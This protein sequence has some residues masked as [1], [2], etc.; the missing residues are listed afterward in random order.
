MFKKA[1]HK[2]GVFLCIIFALSMISVAVSNKT[3]TPANQTKTP[4]GPP[5]DPKS[6]YGQKVIAEKAAKAQAIP[7]SNIWRNLAAYK[8]LAQLDTTNPK[9]RQKVALYQQ[10]VNEANAESRSNSAK[11]RA[12]ARPT[13][14]AQTRNKPADTVDKIEAWNINKQF[15]EDRLKAPSTAKWGS[16]LGEF[17]DPRKCVTDLGNGRFECR[18][19]VDSQNSFGAMI[20][21]HFVSK[22]RHGSDGWYL[23]DLQA[24]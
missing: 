11:A 22:V 9:Y 6:A 21:T 14:V 10:K 1:L 17:Q 4:A 23:E 24:N 8:E 3:K 19:W 15:I 5:I 12:K 2:I 18:G 16:M 20:R 13:T 7:A